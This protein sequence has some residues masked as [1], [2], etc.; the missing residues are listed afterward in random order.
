MDKWPDK[1]Q[2]PI[3]VGACYS[4]VAVPVTSRRWLSFLR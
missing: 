3:A 4:S 1:P 2:E